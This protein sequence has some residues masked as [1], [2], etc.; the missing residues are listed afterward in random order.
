LR[1][2]ELERSEQPDHPFTLFNLGSIL[3][4]RDQHGEALMAMRRNLQLSQLSDSIMR[5]PQPTLYTTRR[6]EQTTQSA[7]NAGRQQN[8]MPPARRIAKS[9]LDTD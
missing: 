7:P 8:A 6:D 2:V 4:E 3:Q 5:Q 1:L 9:A